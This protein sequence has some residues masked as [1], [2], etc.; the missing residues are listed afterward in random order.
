MKD[1]PG[2][3]APR[4]PCCLAF[5][6]V[7]AEFR[8]VSTAAK[9]SGDKAVHQQEKQA[10]RKRA[11][12]WLG[13]LEA[14][15][16]ARPSKVRKVYRQKARE[17]LAVTNHALAAC[18]GARGWQH[19]LRT[20]D[21][22]AVVRRAWPYM[23]VPMDQGSDGW[24][25]MMYLQY[26]LGANAEPYPDFS[27]GANND[28]QLALKD[29]MLFGHETLM[30]VVFNLPYAPWD[31][32]RRWHEQR[33]SFEEYFRDHDESDPLFVSM[34]MDIADDKG[35][36]HAMVE[37]GFARRIWRELIQEPWFWTRG[38]MV[39][40]GRFLSTVEK[41]KEELPLWNTR[42]LSLLYFCLQTGQLDRRRLQEL[43]EKKA[44]LQLRTVGEDADEGA[45]LRQEAQAR[46]FHLRQVCQNTLHLSVLMLMD[47]ENKVRQRIK[48]TLAGPVG[49]WQSKA[50][51]RCR[52]AE[53]IE[54]FMLETCSGAYVDCLRDILL[55]LGRASTL[56]YCKVLTTIGQELLG[57][58]L[59][60][61]AVG[62]QN[63]RA[64]LMGDLALR[65]VYHRAKRGLWLLRG[66]PVRSVLFTDPR[67]S[68]AALASFRRD[69]ENFRALEQRSEIL[70]ATMVRRSVF[71]TTPV[72][73]LQGVCE[74]A[75]WEATE[76]LVAWSRDRACL[77]VNSQIAEDS[78]QRHRKAEGATGTKKLRLLKTWSTLLLRQVADS[79]HR[80]K[81]LPVEGV[82]R[83]RGAR[84]PTTLFQAS[85]RE[86]PK[87]LRA[88]ASFSSRPSWWTSK[89]DTW[90]AVFG[91]LILSEVLCGQNRWHEADNAWLS[92]VLAGTW[93]LLRR[94][95]STCT[96]CVLGDICGTVVAC[97][98]AKSVNL[99]PAG[100]E[101]MH[102]WALDLD[103]PAK[104]CLRFIAIL[105]L[106][107]WR[108]TPFQ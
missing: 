101:P 29:V 51:A 84:L 37:P 30:C 3:P 98:K 50:S 47:P 34:L 75:R 43:V 60:H 71:R 28:F 74:E 57:L 52:S 4:R 58:S 78:F 20:D 12:A 77:A 23:R 6:Q 91:D 63:Q 35:L 24:S 54:T 80:Y 96:M 7:V 31:E 66:W 93:T 8:G 32:G 82:A 99:R 89:A 108:A 39:K 81:P 22:D 59:G 26:A 97:W 69:C 33:Q 14:A 16:N 94:V 46:D 102:C 62:I 45:P 36:A 25:A 40:L 73:Q 55:P 64:Q 9:E 53:D 65:L 61:P 15:E 85:L 42:L 13:A 27:H 76:E 2:H 90:P 38:K 1:A 87:E 92:G 11:K 105:N 103:D 18:T 56:G 17:W 95:D 106:N 10:W 67:Y 72:Q 21:W 68:A 104:F 48:V 107:E 100:E 5:H 83:E 44:A 79:V 88:V 41:A 49:E 70:C 86:C 19:Y